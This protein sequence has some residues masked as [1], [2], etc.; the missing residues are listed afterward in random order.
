MDRFEKNKT[1]VTRVTRH[2]LYLPLVLINI[3]ICH[4]CHDSTFLTS[5]PRQTTNDAEVQRRALSR[6]DL[7]NLFNWSKFKVIWPRF[8][9]K[10]QGTVTM[11]P[12]LKICTRSSFLACRVLVS[13]VNTEVSQALGCANNARRSKREREAWCTP[14]N[15]ANSCLST[16]ET[17]RGRASL[18]YV[19]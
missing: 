18:V 2:L 9:N 17:S 4:Q 7:S 8:R 16:R 6:I 10:S 1:R 12:R 19:D 3:N 15:A 14:W 5:Q 11:P 13:S